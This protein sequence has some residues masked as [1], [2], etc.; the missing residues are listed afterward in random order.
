MSLALGLAMLVGFG[1]NAQ[2]VAP[3]SAPSVGVASSKQASQPL[4]LGAALQ[5]AIDN[6]PTLS[7]ARREIDAAQGALTH[8]GVY[9]NQ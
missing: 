3:S 2:H 5:S 6:S 4:T 7:A 8:A 1:A 9:Q